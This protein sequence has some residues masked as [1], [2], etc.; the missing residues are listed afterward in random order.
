MAR[1]FEHGESRIAVWYMEECEERHLIG[2]Y[3]EVT[4]NIPN[5]SA[6]AWKAFFESCFFIDGIGVREVHLAEINSHRRRLSLHPIAVTE[7]FVGDYA[8]SS[9][10]AYKAKARQDWR[11]QYLDLDVTARQ[12]WI[13]DCEMAIASLEPPHRTFEEYQR[14][15][16][17]QTLRDR[18]QVH[19]SRERERRSLAL[20][21]ARAEEERAVAAQSQKRP[22]LRL[23]SMPDRTLRQL[24]R[25]IWQKLSTTIQSC[26]WCCSGAAWIDPPNRPAPRAPTEPL[27]GRVDQ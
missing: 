19:A 7:T 10:R 23:R 4:P 11:D 6:S 13:K 20:S 25:W 18:E 26:R 22:D 15:L 21:A 17:E 12:A 1:K 3:L 2:M 16:Q 5:D 9:D 24:R 14:D 8:R 27:K